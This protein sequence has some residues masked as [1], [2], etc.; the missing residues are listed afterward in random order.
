VLNVLWIFFMHRGIKLLVR[1]YVTSQYILSIVSL[2]C[3]VVMFVKIKEKH[4]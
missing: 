4:S 1:T 3:L 2:K